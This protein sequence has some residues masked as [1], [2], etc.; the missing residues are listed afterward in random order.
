[1]TVST[2]NEFLKDYEKL[3]FNISVIKD[4][5]PSITVKEHIDSTAINRKIYTGALSDDYG[6]KKLE[7]H[8][9]AVGNDSLLKAD[10]PIKGQ[11]VDRFV[12]EFPTSNTLKESVAYEFYFEV[13]DNDGLRGGKT[14][15]S[16][17][18]HYKKLSSRQLQDK[19][20]ENQQQTIDQL[21]NSVEES[22][23]RKQQLEEI[24]S[25]NKQK[26]QLN[27]NDKRRIDQFLSRQ[28]Q[29]NE[30]ME[31]FQN[32]LKENLNEFQK[33]NKEESEFNKLLKERLERR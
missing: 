23:I 28:L 26:N 4:K 29:Q 6:I 7:V 3:N 17:T 22:E 18:F 13:T 10:I 19:Q 20:L 31:K 32:K 11:N 33:N 21:Q 30:M 16:Q 12:Y 8:Y 14:S 15:K 24:N 5:Y 2:N 9:N 25:V 1:Y 27:F